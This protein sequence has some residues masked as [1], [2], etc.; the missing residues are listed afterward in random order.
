M[1]EY[2]RVTSTYKQGEGRWDP[3]DNSLNVEKMRNNNVLGTK[4][5]RKGDE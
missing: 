5:I 4:G 1:V 3:V 2:I